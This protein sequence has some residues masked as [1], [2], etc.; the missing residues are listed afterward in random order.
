MVK[1]DHGRGLGDGETGLR[2]VGIC[3]GILRFARGE[4]EEM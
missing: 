1:P 4:S 3:G 2:A